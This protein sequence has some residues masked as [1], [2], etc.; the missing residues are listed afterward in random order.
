MESLASRKKMAMTGSYHK[1][2][3]NRVS[4]FAAMIAAPPIVIHAG[5]QYGGMHT[6]E[7]TE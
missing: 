2:Y 7:M 4:S 1:N 5:L 6:Y 3:L